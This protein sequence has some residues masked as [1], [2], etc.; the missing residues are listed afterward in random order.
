MM[1]TG[2]K[3]INSNVT[4][5]DCT[6][7]GWKEAIRAEGNTE[8]TMINSKIID[9]R[10]NR[11]SI[12]DEK[13]NFFK[14]KR[15]DRCFCSSGKKYKN[16]CLKTLQKLNLDE[17]KNICLLIGNGFNIS[18]NK[19]LERKEQAIGMDSSEFLGWNIKSP[20][21]NIPFLDHLPYLKEFLNNNDIKGFDKLNNFEKVEKINQW[22]KDN[23]S[24]LLICELKHYIAIAFSS[25]QKEFDKKDISKWKGT[26]I[27]KAL[28]GRLSYAIS[29]NYDLVLESVLDIVNINY[30]R[31]GS[32]T[33]AETK[34]K[35]LKPHGSIDFDVSG[36]RVP[37]KYPLVNVVDNN[38]CG[39]QV[40]E[41]ANLL[42][43]R[44]EVDIVLPLDYSYQTEYQWIKPGYDYIRKAGKEFTD[45]I[46]F[47]VSYG[48]CD[49]KE[50]DL[51]ID[52]LSES[53]RVTV[54][55]TKVSQ[56][57]L[58]KL[59]SKVGSTN[60]NVIKDINKI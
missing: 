27:L 4:V 15:K 55:D 19:Y 58:K 33:E 47:G 23:N 40:I 22:A 48:E 16:C 8:I 41:R 20:Q 56:E 29:L 42:K 32:R 30:K 13:C 6:F 60:V 57:L 53:S 10:N 7:S 43:C 54:I 2:I 46:I 35:I 14:V 5:V 39:I 26:S 11:N 1:N 25:F 3:V 45:L 28:E 21:E 12:K 49:R 37:L 44:T 17:S 24:K 18:A 51:I 9:T 52:S 59:C 36:I 34:V 38:D 50:I 31:V